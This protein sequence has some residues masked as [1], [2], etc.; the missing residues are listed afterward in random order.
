MTSHRNFILSL[1]MILVVSL[2]IY[3]G[4]RQP[5]INPSNISITLSD[6]IWVGIALFINYLLLA[7]FV[8]KP[9]SQLLSTYN[10]DKKLI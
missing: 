5:A 7:S 2:A 9:R 4:T 1:M 8:G 3:I 6:D 10:P